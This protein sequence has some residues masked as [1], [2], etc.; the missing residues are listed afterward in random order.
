VDAVNHPEPLLEPAPIEF[1]ESYEDGV[2]DVYPPDFRMQ[3]GF[4]QEDDRREA[5]C[6]LHRIAA[7]T[8]A[9]ARA[10]RG[11]RILDDSEPREG[12]Y[13]CFIVPRWASKA[14][15]ARHIIAWMYREA[16]VTRDRLEVLFVGDSYPDLH[17]ALV[18]GAGMAAT[19]LLVG[20]SRLA[21]VLSEPETSEFAGIDFRAMKRR[22]VRT[23][24]PGYLRYRSPCS[25]A[26]LTVIV[27]D[28]AFPS[29]E[30]AQTV[31]RYLAS[32]G[33]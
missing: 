20:G 9:L 4:A 8:N 24:R 13:K 3:L 15:A 26:P 33:S 25:A 17:M 28:R 6:R 23:D 19:L 1:V 7:A 32:V 30:S 21:D 10:A 31:E 16:G 5:E 27:G 2:S 29:T 11:V 22:L 12:R 18:G 14:R